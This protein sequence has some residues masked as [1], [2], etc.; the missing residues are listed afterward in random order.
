[1]FSKISRGKPV[2]SWIEL[3]KER[4][5]EINEK[6]E[7]DVHISRSELIRTQFTHPPPPN[8]TKND[9]HHPLRP[10]RPRLPQPQRSK[11]RPARP[12]PHRHRPRP[13]ARPSRAPSPTPRAS[14]TSWRP[15]SAAP[16]TRPSTPSRPSPP[17][18]AR[19]S[20][21]SPNSRRR[22]PCPATRAPR[23][24]PS[25]P[26]S[27]PPSICAWCA[28]AGTPRPADGSPRRRRSRRAPRDARL[29][30]REL[31]ARAEKEEE[32]CAEDVHIVVVSHG[33]FLHYITDDVP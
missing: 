12:P 19:K 13:N 21:R 20:S 1:M 15:P 32:G 25:P 9:H 27:P 5:L 2:C 6:S 3:L 22:P 33:N 18:A 28:T 29:W 30:L 10:P 24:P 14:R 17:P 26:S 11:P 16:S 4:R 7:L 8:P 31:G 23:P